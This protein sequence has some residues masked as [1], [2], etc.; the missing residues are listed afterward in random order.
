MPA[1]QLADPLV[2]PLPSSQVATV[3]EIRFDSPLDNLRL[4]KP[5]SKI[6]NGSGHTRYDQAA[7]E[8]VNLA[9]SHTP[10]EEQPPAGQRGVFFLAADF[11]INSYVPIA[12][13][14]TEL[15]LPLLDPI[16]PAKV[17]MKSK[18]KLTAVYLP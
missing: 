7:M 16:V 13:L 10:K 14:G 17:S 9:L 2:D 8:G 12:G 18:V 5:S 11:S 15:V 6:L 4:Q 1:G 3:I